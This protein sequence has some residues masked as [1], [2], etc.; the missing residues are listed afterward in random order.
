MMSANFSSGTFFSRLAM[1]L[2]LDLLV[3]QQIGI[4]WSVRKPADQALNP[5]VVIES[6]DYVDSMRLLQGIE[7][8]E[9]ESAAKSNSH[10]IFALRTL[11]SQNICDWE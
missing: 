5:T 8:H 4:Y 7:S 1:I 6:Q 10:L 2:I 11:S 9:M 3:D